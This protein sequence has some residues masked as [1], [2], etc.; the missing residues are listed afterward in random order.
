VHESGQSAEALQVSAHT[1]VLQVV[2]HFAPALQS[3]VQFPF[4]QSIEQMEPGAH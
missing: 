4:S 2:L 1:D 3:I